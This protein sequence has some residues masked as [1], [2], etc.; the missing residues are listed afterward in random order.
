MGLQRETLKCAMWRKQ[1]VSESPR[2]LF[3]RFLKECGCKPE[4]SR[5]PV[6]NTLVR[7]H[8]QE[9]CK[10]GYNAPLRQKLHHL[11]CHPPQLLSLRLTSSQ[12][13]VLLV[14]SRTLAKAIPFQFL[15]AISCADPGTRRRAQQPQ[16]GLAPF[17]ALQMGRFA[18]CDHKL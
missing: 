13:V 1:V 15:P 12:G 18:R 5:I 14:C 6:T 8:D 17:R 3:Q 7:A 16:A 4:A 11:R 10:A 2:T 9:H